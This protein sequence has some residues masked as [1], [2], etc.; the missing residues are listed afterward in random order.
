MRKIISIL[1]GIVLIITMSVPVYASTIYEDVEALTQR[2]AELE[3]QVTALTPVD[4]GWLDLPLSNGAVAYNTAQKPQY[5]KIG[6]H[7]Y[8]RGVLKNVNTFPTTVA[9]LPEGFRPAQRIIYFIATNG[10]N[11]ARLELETDGRINIVAS[12]RVDISAT[13]H[14]SFGTFGFLID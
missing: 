8:I 6:N 2:V 7:V 5:R 9:Q 12:D 13:T 14:Y 1:L 4:S 11:T 3:A 10:P